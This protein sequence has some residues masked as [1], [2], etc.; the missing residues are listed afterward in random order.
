MGAN[1]WFDSDAPATTPRYSARHRKP[2]PNVRDLL[3]VGR[4]DPAPE[5][6]CDGDNDDLAES[7]DADPD[8]DTGAT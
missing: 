5:A 2:L 7:S 8:Q 1:R 3:G 6:D 4:G